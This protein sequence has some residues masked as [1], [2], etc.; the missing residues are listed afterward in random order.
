MLP[1]AHNEARKA[2]TTD[3]LNRRGTSSKGI[4]LQTVTG[5]E[6]RIHHVAHKSKQPP[7]QWHLTILPWKTFKGVPLPGLI[8][9]PVSLNAKKSQCLPSAS[10][11]S[12]KYTWIVSLPRQCQETQKCAHHSHQK[13]WMECF[14]T[15]N[16]TVLTS[17]HQIFT[18]LL[19]WWCTHHYMNNAM[20]NSMW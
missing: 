9:P 3:V 13:I 11:S 8:T 10:L 2:N 6:T 16:H 5:H 1:D 12:K 20:Q 7:M 4:P 17:H 14:N 15:P 19:L 18:C